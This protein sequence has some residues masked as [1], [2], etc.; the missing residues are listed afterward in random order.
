MPHTISLGG[1]AVRRTEGLAL[2]LALGF[3]LAGGTALVVL[4]GVAHRRL[5]K[6]PVAVELRGV[7]RWTQAAVAGGEQRQEGGGQSGQGE[8]ARVS[9][10]PEE[11]SVHTRREAPQPLRPSSVPLVGGVDPGTPSNRAV[12]LREDDPIAGESNLVVPPGAT[13]G[14]PGAAAAASTAETQGTGGVERVGSGGVNH[15]V[16][17]GARAGSGSGPG[18]DPQRLLALVRSKIRAHRRYPELARRRGIEGKVEVSFRI[19]PDGRV[20]ELM[21]R[22]GA[23]PMLDEAALA[24]VRAASP[25][26]PFPEPLTVELD[27]GLED[28]PAAGA[29]AAP[30]E[31]EEF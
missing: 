12:E 2:G 8:S 25:L 27:F 10:V 13:A 20:A 30:Q 7:L 11:A 9:V 24:A 6:E 4:S 17:H 31:E 3:H 14:G 18:G 29:P 21:V 16:G 23:D 26:P 22:R 28:G 19:L 15:G 1:S 5:Q